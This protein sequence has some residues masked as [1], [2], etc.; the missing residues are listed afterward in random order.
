MVFLPPGSV[1]GQASLPWAPHRPPLA[2][3]AAAALEREHRAELERLSSSLEA[4]HREVRCSRPWAAWQSLRPA[5]LVTASRPLRCWQAELDPRPATG[6]GASLPLKPL[7]VG[8]WAP[9]RG[10]PEAVPWH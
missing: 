7:V 1:P 4:K 6:A 9:S 5:P 10:V 8:C 3:Q 2:P